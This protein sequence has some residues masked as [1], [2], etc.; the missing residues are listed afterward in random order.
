MVGTWTINLLIG[1][2][3][4]MLVFISAYSLNPLFT[5]LIRGSFAFVSFFL[6]SYLI[7]WILHF[8]IH[9][10]N[11][12]TSKKKSHEIE[13]SQLNQETTSQQSDESIKDEEAKRAA[14][15]IKDLLK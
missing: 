12:N 7:R 8:I 1:M 5:S 3:G 13:Q 10:T 15:L 4:F 9:D 6:I 2:F 14:E 11:G